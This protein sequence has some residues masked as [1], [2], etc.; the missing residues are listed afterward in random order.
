MWVTEQEDVEEVDRIPRVVCRHDR[1]RVQLSFG[2]CGGM[3]NYFLG[4]A[5]VLQERFHMDNVVFS[6][7]SAGCFPALLLAMNMDIK[8]QYETMHRD[9]LAEA[10]TKSL[11]NWIPIV[12]KHTLLNLPEDAHVQASGR[13]FCSLTELPWLTNHLIGEYHDNQDLVD[14]ILASGY[15]GFYAPSLTK[16]Y[17][18]KKF[19]DGSVSNNSPRPYPNEPSKVIQL[20]HYRWFNPLSVAI[21]TDVNWTQQLFENGRHDA[22][23]NLDDFSSILTLKS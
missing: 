23:V 2:G 20:W 5:S 16:P 11:R 18:G 22:L 1:Q 6:G 13:L 14:C 15:V 12:G 3:Y 7:S 21:S 19:I 17:R 4:I 10:Q 8:K 9:I